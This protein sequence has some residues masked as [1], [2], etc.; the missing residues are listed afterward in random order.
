MRPDFVSGSVGEELGLGG[1]ERMTELAGNFADC[2]SRR[3]EVVCQPEIAE[4]QGRLFFLQERMKELKER[5]HQA[6]PPGDAKTRRRRCIYYIVVAA[7]LTLSGFFFALLAFDPFQFGWKSYVYCIAVSVVTPFAVDKC[8]DLWSNE[9][10]MRGL[11]ATALLAAIASL[12]LLAL[13]RGEILLQHIQAMDSTVL[14][15]LDEPLQPKEQT[16]F[17]ENT[18]I[19]IRATMALL[20]VA[21]EIG[22]GLA[23]HDAWRFAPDS[24]D[25]PRQLQAELAAIHEEI[26]ACVKSMALLQNM[27]EEFLNTFWRDF[28]RAMLIGTVRKAII[29]GVLG[30]ALLFTLGSPAIAAEPTLNIVVAIDLS[31]SLRVRGMDGKTEHERNVAAI[32]KLL[33]TMPAGSRVTIIAITDRSFAQPYVLLSAQLTEDPGYFKERI[34]AA[35]KQLMRAWLKVSENARPDF[36]HTDVIGAL[37]LA[38][39]ILSETPQAREL[40]IVFSDMRHEAFGI[41][42]ESPDFISATQAFNGVEYDGLVARLQG[43]DVYVAGA[44]APGKLPTYWE[45]LRFFWAKYFTK[46]GANLKSFTVTRDLPQLP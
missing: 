37:M 26:I 42:L 14:S 23:L 29:K 31:R 7:I 33:S 13:I 21:M 9:K 27:S 38:G 11:A 22:A 34:T 8:L 39:Q 25:D 45:S 30:F 1:V 17:Y 19:W 2:E 15:G 18:A 16:N 3:I 44:I 32:T 24:G 43:V 40:L 20:A 36:P 28:Y 35:R 4:R 12:V 46:A 5:L 41:N 6:L 10:L